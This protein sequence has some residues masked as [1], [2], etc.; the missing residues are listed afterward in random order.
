MHIYFNEWRA[1]VYGVV[2]FLSPG[3]PNRYFPH[4]APTPCCTWD[5]SFFMPCQDPYPYPSLQPR[6]AALIEH[7]GPERLLWGSDFPFVSDGQCG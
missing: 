2:L 3:R 4:A 5:A 1:Y 7:F 6:F